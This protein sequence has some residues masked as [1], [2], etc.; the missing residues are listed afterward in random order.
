MVPSAVVLLDVLPLTP[1]G[2]L[3]RKALPDPEPTAGVKAD[4]SN[5]TALEEHIREVFAE[6]LGVDSVGVED[7]F[8]ALGG[9]SLLAVQAVARLKERGLSFYVRDVFAAP[10]V[11]GLMARMSLSSLRDVLDVLLPIREQGDEPP[12]FCIHPGGGMSWCYMPMARFAPGG[13]PLY[14]LQAR[15]LNGESAFAAS[16]TEMAYDYIEQIRTVQ[17]TGP[18]R[19]LGWSF[20]GQVAHEVAVRLQ[21]AGEEVSTLIILDTYPPPRR[22]DAEPVDGDGEDGPA[23]IELMPPPDPDSELLAL[24]EWVRRTAGPLGGLSDDECLFF[25]RLFLNNQ[26]IAIE[27][28]YGRFDGEA[29]VLVAGKD[30]PEDAPTARDWEP[31]VS[32]TVSEAR[33]PC[34]H[35]QM[36]D[37]E[38]LGEVWSAI[39]GSLGTEGADSPDR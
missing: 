13:I 22:V 2:K 4:N 31:Y 28:T 5:I 27:H 29:L 3:D 1:N 38:W 17:A 20:G 34:I 30:R 35:S 36:V 37:P 8:F 39:A 32:G 11:S 18:Y 19:L 14:A 12:V 24:R 10:T 6:V 33:I 16:L 9:H 21:E 23:D 7:D 26:R 25:A 15:G